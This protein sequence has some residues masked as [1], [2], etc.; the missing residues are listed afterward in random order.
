[1]F[2]VA[3]ILPFLP[4]VLLV[5]LLVRVLRPVV[6]IRFGSLPSSL[7]GHFAAN[8]E[9]YLCERDAGLHGNRVIDIFF[10]PADVSNLQLKKMWDR[11]LNVSQLARL[12]DSVSRKLPGG[13]SHI[14]PWRYRQDRDVFGLLARTN[15]HINFTDEEETLGRAGLRELGVPEDSSFVCFHVRDSAYRAIK[16]PGRDDYHHQYRNASVLNYLPA[17]E[18]LANRSYYSLRMGALVENPLPATHSNIIDYASNGRADFLDI[19]L[20]ARCR[21]F[22]GCH[23]GID[24]VAAIFRKPIVYANQ[25]PLIQF[26][27]WGKDDLVVPKLLW[28]RK[29]KRYLTF[30]EIL[31][32]EIGHFLNTEQYDHL[33]IDVVENTPEEITAAVIEMDDRLKG[34]WEPADEDED[35][36]RRF[37]SLYQ[38]DDENRTFLSRVGA[39]FLRQ[40]KD[41]LE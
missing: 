12:P 15:P 28:L 22:L 10:H 30:Q 20:T 14:I 27:T 18:E 25:V 40:H 21:F 3:K 5:V 7:I 24:A 9:V 33:G 11:K 35:L 38:P 6:A 23:G 36:Q 32:S 34:T 16:F 26:P 31:S 19:Y 1:M 4:C 8:P 37:L 13:Q 2:R 41:L 39:D 29:D 17:A